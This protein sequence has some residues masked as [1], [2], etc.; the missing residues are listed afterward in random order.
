MN[1]IKIVSRDH[2]AGAELQAFGERLRVMHPERLES[3]MI[4]ELRREKQAVVLA[5]QAQN[6][7]IAIASASRLLREGR[8]PATAPVCGFLI[9]YAGDEWRRC[10]ASWIEHYSE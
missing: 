9:G 1:A 8:W 10:G 7:A 3:A 2:A 4:D 5:L 6:E